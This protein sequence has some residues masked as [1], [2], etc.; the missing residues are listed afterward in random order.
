MKDTPGWASPGS[1]PSDGQEP[2][3]T[4]PAEPADRPGPAQQP[5]ADPQGPDSKWSK[6]QPPYPPG[7]P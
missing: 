4:G 1:V 5:G 7:A 6:E 3:A 2:G